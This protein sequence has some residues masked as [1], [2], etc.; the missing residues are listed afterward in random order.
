MTNVAI[1]FVEAY[2]VDYSGTVLV[3][4]GD[5]TQRRMND[6]DLFEGQVSGDFLQ[7]YLLGCLCLL[8]LNLNL[9]SCEGVEVIIVIES[10]I[11]DGLFG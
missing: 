4:V 6:I 9:W 10:L 11:E 3:L 5:L 2:T 1:E 8:F 7:S